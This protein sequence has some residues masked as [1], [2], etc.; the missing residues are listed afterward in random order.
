MIRA[1]YLQVPNST[2]LAE[3][4]NPPHVFHDIPRPLKENARITCRLLAKH[5][6]FITRGCHSMQVTNAIPQPRRRTNQN[7]SDLTCECHT[8]ST[9]AIK[10]AGLLQLRQLTTEQGKSTLAKTWWLTGY[11]LVACFL[12]TLFRLQFFWLQGRITLGKYHERYVPGIWNQ[13]YSCKTVNSHTQKKSFACRPGH[14]DC[15]AYNY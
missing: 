1:S 7:S 10:A 5:L 14:I 6:Q 9:P 4:N 11:L 15:G 12:T 3:V 8:A 13:Q 2:L